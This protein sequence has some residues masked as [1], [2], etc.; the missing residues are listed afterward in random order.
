MAIKAILFY[1]PEC[2]VPCDDAFESIKKVTGVGEIERMDITEGLKK[3]ELGDPEGV[4]FIAFI[5]EATGKCINKAFFHD[6]NGN[7]VIQRYP[8][9]ADKKIE[10]TRR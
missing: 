6:E 9:I 1:D 10:A 7:L 3:Y 5:S 2:G 8:S 4:P